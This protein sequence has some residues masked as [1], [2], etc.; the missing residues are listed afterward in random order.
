M[1]LVLGVYDY[2]P[3][4]Y[5]YKFIDDS[6]VLSDIN[7]RHP[8]IR[9]VDARSIP[10]TNIG[11]IYA[12][13]VLEHIPQEEVLFTLIHWREVL[14]P[15]GDVH[16]NVPDVEW[17]LDEWMRI[18]CGKPPTSTYFTDTKRMLEIIH[19]DGSTDHDTHKSW[20][21]YE[22]LLDLMLAAGFSEVTVDKVYEAHDMQC[23]IAKGFKDVPNEQGV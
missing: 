4:P 11:S 16:I 13:H 2:P 19:G 6:W 5:H 3:H 18:N 17:A 21:T 15:G 20:F 10:Y 8:A 23:L 12:S 14:A 9:K 22:R 1:K 7:P